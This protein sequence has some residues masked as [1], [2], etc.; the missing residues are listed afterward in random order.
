MTYMLKRLRLWWISKQ[1][2][3]HMWRNKRLQKLVV[4][5]DE[6]SN[7]EKERMLTL[8]DNDYYQTAAVA[9]AYELA[10]PKRTKGQ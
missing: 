3:I 9:M 4:R 5:C 8:L 10:Y 6:A 2:K 1:A 7:E